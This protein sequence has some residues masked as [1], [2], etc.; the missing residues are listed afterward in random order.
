MNKTQDNVGLVGRCFVIWGSKYEWERHGKVVEVLRD[1]HYLV[2]FFEAAFG[3]PSTLAVYH[4]SQFAAHPPIADRTDGF[5]EFFVD[6][7]HLRQWIEA[8]Q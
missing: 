2:Q 7:A 5:I 1:G 6:E 4:V 8:M 3:A